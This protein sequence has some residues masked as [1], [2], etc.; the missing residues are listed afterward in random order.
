[1]NFTESIQQQLTIQV[2]KVRVMSFSDQ[3]KFAWLALRFARFAL[4]HTR[5]LPESL[6]HDSS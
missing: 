5:S 6:L 2:N 4:Q 1:M 3:K